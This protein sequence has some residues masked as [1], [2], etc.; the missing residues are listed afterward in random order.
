MTTDLSNYG[1]V[2]TKDILARRLYND[3]TTTNPVGIIINSASKCLDVTAGTTIAIETTSGDI[4]IVSGADLSFS[5]VANTDLVTA[6]NLTL[7]ATNG[8]YQLETGGACNVKPTGGY[9]F[10][11]G[12]T[13]DVDAVG[14]ITIDS[15]A[16]ISIG[17]ETDHQAINVGTGG[18]R[19]ITIGQTTSS[20]TT[21]AVSGTT[22]DINCGTGGFNVDCDEAG[23]VAINARGAPSN[24][25][26]LSTAAADDLTIALTGATNSSLVLS[27][28]GTAADAIQMT[29]SAGG[30]D[31]SAT[32]APGE[33][34]DVTATGAS[35]NIKATES[36]SD[37]ITIVA[38]TGGIDISASGAAAGEDIDIVATGSSVNIKSTESATDAVTIVATTGGIDISASGASAGEDIDITATG[39]SVNITSTENTADAVTIVASAGGIDISATG[40]AGEDIDVTN[41]GGSVNIS[42]TESTADAI[43]IVATA[44]GIDIS[45]SG[46]AA[47][48]DIDIV[49]TGSS[50]NIK[51]TEVDGSAITLNASGGGMTVNAATTYVST[52]GTT[53]NSTVTGD[54][55]ETFQAAKAENVTGA[56]T[57][58]FSNSR[59]TTIAGN[60]SCTITGTLD[61]GVTGATTERYTGNRSVTNAGTTTEVLTGAETIT[62]SA[63]SSRTCTTQYSVVSNYANAA[64]IRLNAAAGAGGIDIDAGSAGIAVD[65]T[66][67]LTLNSVGTTN[68]TT[69]ASGANLTVKCTG[70]STQVLLIESAGTG[71]NAIDVNATAGGLD[72]DINGAIDIKSTT[73]NIAINAGTG[74]TKNIKIGYTAD[75]NVYISGTAG[76]SGQ[77]GNLGTCYVQNLNIAGVLTTAGNTTN[78]GDLTVAG[79]LTVNGTTTT[80]NTATITAD[81]INIELNS[82]ASPTNAQAEGGGITLKG[83]TDKSMIWAAAT[84]NNTNAAWKFTEDIDIAAGKMYTIG[85]YRALTRESVYVDTGDGI[86]GNDLLD[87]KPAI[88]LNQQNPYTPA[89]NNWRI[90]VDGAGDVVFQKRATADANSWQNKFRIQ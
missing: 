52:V 71:S 46:A 23:A 79:N 8:Y 11:G 2:T 25:T 4:D 64:A 42:A 16:T 35:I 10:T 26:L 21:V 81:D 32:S 89:I 7:K 17:A 39:S 12:A 22:L 62:N 44:G 57:E 63:S 66:G 24:L 70:G 20:T 72:V 36:A 3:E 27:S 84:T 80:L 29:A 83:S 58:T 86:V 41:T 87:N 53:S 31:I 56:I 45:A 51:A 61:L 34:I 18:N 33:D 38:T 47:G 30:I 40:A 6:T 59:T 75:N 55:T 85:K 77:A 76:T 50:V 1:T 88:Y 14:A 28:T 74:I 60:E 19:P 13:Y 15:D 49:A 78:S 65:T 68:L 82:V 48:E 73:D 9:T 43:T 5:V 90:K 67:P 69:T 37:A 54:A